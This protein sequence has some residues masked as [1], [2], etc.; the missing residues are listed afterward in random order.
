MDTVL[1][2]GHNRL[3]KLDDKT[4]RGKFVWFQLRTLCETLLIL[5]KLLNQV[6][7]TT[8]DVIAAPS[9]LVKLA[10]NFH[11]ISSNLISNS[12]SLN[13]NVRSQPTSWHL[14]AWCLPFSTRN[15]FFFCGSCFHKIQTLINQTNKSSSSYRYK[16]RKVKIIWCIG[17][18]YGVLMRMFK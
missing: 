2:L 3:E 9:H 10:S 13:I 15:L 17:L 1:K 12:C 11:I 16:K 18:R 4:I 5:S 14:N 7:N 8:S 6:Y